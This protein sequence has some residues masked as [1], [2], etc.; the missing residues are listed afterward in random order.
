[1]PIEKCKS[2]KSKDSQTSVTK[3][4]IY[5]GTSTVMG[6]KTIKLERLNP[7]EQS[8]NPSWYFSVEEAIFHGCRNANAAIETPAHVD[9]IKKYAGNILLCRFPN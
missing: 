9:T 2:D 5:F 3:R 4:A 1:M 7:K 8:K 6:V